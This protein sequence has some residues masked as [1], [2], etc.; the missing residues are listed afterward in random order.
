MKTI[1]LEEAY[2]L[3]TP[4]PLCVSQAYGIGRTIGSGG[5]ASPIGWCDCVGHPNELNAALLAHAFNVLPVVVA[6]L[7]DAARELMANHAVD[8]VRYAEKNPG[9]PPLPEP[10]SMVDIRAALAK[11]NQVEVP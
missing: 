4:G 10:I 1:T 5:D 3:A 8:S 2:K 7:E 11:A 6:A 9:L